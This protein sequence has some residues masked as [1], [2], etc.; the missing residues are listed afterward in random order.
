V[1]AMT[2]MLIPIDGGVGVV[3]FQYN[4]T[5][6]NRQA[7]SEYGSIEVK[8]KEGPLLQYANG[9][10]QSITLE[11]EAIRYSSDSDVQNLVDA[12]EGLTAPSVSTGMTKKAPRVRFS[13]GGATPK[14]NSVVKSVSTK[15]MESLPGSC[16]PFRAQISV[17]LWRWV[18]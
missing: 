18:D 10:Q 4:P 14:W 6:Y 1:G 12:L 9:S 11:L 15:V 2:G 16:L 5:G 17:T 8:G 3:K 7:G 13:Y